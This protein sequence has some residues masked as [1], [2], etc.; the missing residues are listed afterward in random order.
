MYLK[1]EDNIPENETEEEMYIRLKSKARKMMFN[2]KGV[3]FAPWLMRQIDEDAIVKDLVRK[4]KG[5]KREKTNANLLDRGEIEASEGMSWRMKGNQVELGWTTSNE[6]GNKGFI[7]EKR[8]SYGGDFREVASFY[9]VN[10][11]QTQGPAGGR[12]RYID[13]STAK[14]S[15]IYRVKDCDVSGSQNTLCQCFVEVQTE[16]ESKFQGALTIGFVLAAVA[17]IL[18][19]YNL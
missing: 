4:E 17:G 13:P 3:P 6:S 11:L 9:E 18:V 8:P 14:G 16:E 7:V 1:E 2:S 12:Y 19:T 15:W 10:Q 5:L